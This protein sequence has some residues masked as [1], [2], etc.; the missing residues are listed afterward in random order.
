MALGN[1]EFAA[2]IAGDP[3]AF[4]HYLSAADPVAEAAKDGFE[5]TSNFSKYVNDAFAKVR[6]YIRDQVH[7]LEVKVEQT[8]ST[9]VN[10]IHPN[11]GGNGSPGTGW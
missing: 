11:S 3:K 1:G 10:A 6:V 5:L 9:H 2:R 4:L 7:V 8:K